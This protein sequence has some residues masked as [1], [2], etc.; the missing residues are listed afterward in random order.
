MVMGH[1]EAVR[2]A[3]ESLRANRLRSV[4]TLIGFV[5]GVMT[6]ITVVAFISG[7]NG[8]VA[9]EVFNLGADAIQVNRA[10]AANI[11]EDDFVRVRRRPDLTMTDVE[12]VR[13][14]CSFC[15]AV[16]AHLGASAQVKVGS[17]VLESVQIRGRTEEVADILGEGIEDGRPVNGVDVTRR[18]RVA[19]LGGDVRDA[20]FPI[21]D[22]IGRRVL[23]NGEE[24]EVVGL[25]ERQGAIMGQPRDNWITIPITAFHRIWG[26]N[27]SVTLYAKADGEA[28]V[29]AAS[30]QIRSVLR[31]LHHVPYAEEDDFSLTTNET[32]LELWASIS[33]TFFAVT[34]AIASIALVVGGIV[35]MN[36][37]LVSVTERTREIGVRMA[38]GA[39]RSDILA[40]FLVEAATVTLV[41]G[42]IGILLGA[43]V[44]TLVSWLTGLPAAIRLWS[45]VLGLAVSTGTG[46]FFGIWPARKAARLDPIAALRHE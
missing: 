28:R 15:E 3:L 19:V 24:F 7:L 11:S 45:V 20:L 31:T 9:E 1:L 14:V 16:G 40:Q 34:V 33:Q 44:A 25:G 35:V 12:A 6:I 18:R 4:L 23:I 43:G 2:V 29:A 41:G 37:M 30:D 10:P 22:P 21:L 26:S 32:F 8:F 36:I 46:L 39:R 27:R 5:I 17:E 38:V 13:E 42:V